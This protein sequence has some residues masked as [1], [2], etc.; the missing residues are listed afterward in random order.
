MMFGAPDAE[1]SAPGCRRSLDA[2]LAGGRKYSKF[3]VVGYA[4]SIG[5]I[6]AAV[7]CAWRR[8][9]WLLGDAL[10]RDTRAI[11]QETMAAAARWPTRAMGPGSATGEVSR[12]RP[13]SACRRWSHSRP[14]RQ[15][16]QSHET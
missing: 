1:G 8:T 13:G 15:A 11:L 6:E 9:S 14:Q 7:A 12:V 2:P 5:E 4:A 3:P 16:T 10:W